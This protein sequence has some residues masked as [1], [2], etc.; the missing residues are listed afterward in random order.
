[1]NEQNIP[2]NC[3]V[4]GKCSLC[5]GV[6]VTYSVWHGTTEPP[7]WCLSCGAHKRSPN[8][9]DQLP[10]IEMEKGDNPPYKI[11]WNNCSNSGY[12]F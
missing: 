1:M 7:T 10:E 4:V 6:V 3:I 11:Y 12:Y 2:F 8:W 5:G 9:L